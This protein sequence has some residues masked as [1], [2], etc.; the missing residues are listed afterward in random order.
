MSPHQL[1]QQT[2]TTRQRIRKRG[3][4]LEWTESDHLRISKFTELREDKDRESWSKSTQ[5]KLES[6][7][8]TCFSSSDRR[9]EYGQADLDISLSPV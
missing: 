9:A 2:K 6:T 5:A 1:A 8:N 3:E 4:F 7:Y